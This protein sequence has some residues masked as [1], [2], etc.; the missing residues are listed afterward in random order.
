MRGLKTIYFI[1]IFRM[2]MCVDLFIYIQ[3]KGKNVLEMSNIHF[4]FLKILFIYLSIYLF[5]YSFIRSFIRETE[6]ERE[7][8]RHRQRKKQVPCM[9]PNVGLDPGSPES[10][11][12]LKATLNR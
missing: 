1:P 3:K 9:K 4:F 2:F 6:N 8:Q 12:G 7:R 11:P 5:I 10:G